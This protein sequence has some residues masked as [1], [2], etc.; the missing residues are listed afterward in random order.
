VNKLYVEVYIE[1]V[2]CRRAVF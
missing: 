2:P 1:F